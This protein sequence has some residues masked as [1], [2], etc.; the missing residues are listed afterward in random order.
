MNYPI[1]REHF[2]IVYPLMERPKLRTADVETGAV[3]EYDVV[4]CSETGLRYLI[5]FGPLPEIGAEVSGRV[6]FRRGEVVDIAGTVVR[7]Q[8]SSVALHLVA[9]NI[10]LAT[11]LDEQRY[12]RINYPMHG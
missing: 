2:R 9:S 5:R 12:L 1:E 10:P 4:D 3:E 7:T 8:G 6:H 11:V